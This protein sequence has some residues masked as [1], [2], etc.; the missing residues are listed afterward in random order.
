MAAAGDGLAAADGRFFRTRFFDMT[1]LLVW[2][3]IL[4]TVQQTIELTQIGRFHGHVRGRGKLCL[5]ACQRDHGV[6]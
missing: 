2:Q 3:E 6:G 1:H 5:G 4:K